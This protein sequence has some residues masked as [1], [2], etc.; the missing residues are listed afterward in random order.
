MGLGLMWA[1]VVIVVWAC[2]HSLYPAMWQKAGD[3]AVG[4]RVELGKR[5][6]RPSFGAALIVGLAGANVS[7]SNPPTFLWKGEGQRQHS[8]QARELW[9][10]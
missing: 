8:H 7:E 1:V 5:L 9:Q 2:W 4:R 10:C 6:E 3:V